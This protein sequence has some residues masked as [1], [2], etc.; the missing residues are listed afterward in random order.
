MYLANENLL[1]G[2]VE[3]GETLIG[4][5]NKNSHWNKKMAYS[6]GHS[7][8]DKTPVVGMIQRDFLINALV[9][10]DTTAKTLSAFIKKHVQP[11]SNIYTDENASYNE[12]GKEYPRHVVDHSKNLYSYE[13][14]TTNR[15]EACWTH[16]K[17]MI[18]GAYRNVHTKKYLQKYVDEFIFRYNLRDINASDMFNCFLCC[19]DGRIT[20]KEIKEAKWIELTENKQSLY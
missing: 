13:D 10:G 2:E 8:K 6:Q 19:S 3:T 14:V 20:H 7:H 15:I 9:T 17:R 12:I 16:F 1:M 11:D 4:G 5:R 18:L